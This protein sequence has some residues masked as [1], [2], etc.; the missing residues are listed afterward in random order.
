[1]GIDWASIKTEYITTDTSYRKLR[2]E[3]A[4]EKENNEIRVTISGGLDKYN[5]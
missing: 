2:K 5:T 3:A 4:V 1:M